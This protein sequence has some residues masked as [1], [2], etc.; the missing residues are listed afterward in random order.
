MSIFM[1]NLHTITYGVEDRGIAHSKNNYSKCVQYIGCPMKYMHKKLLNTG[2]NEFFIRRDGIKHVGVSDIWIKLDDPRV[3]EGGVKLLIGGQVIE[4]L[5]TI[6]FKESAEGKFKLTTDHILPMTGV[7]AIT[8]G[9]TCK[10]ASELVYTY[11][12]VALESYTY[13]DCMDILFTSEQYTRDCSSL[14]FTHPVTRLDVYTTEPVS[15]LQ[16]ATEHTDVFPLT[17][18][19]TNRNHNHYVLDFKQYTVNFTKLEKARLIRS[20]TAPLHIVGTYRNILRYLDGMYGLVY[21]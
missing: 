13:N 8:I 3:I 17:L 2:Y 4:T 9:I 16:F 18:H 5:H 10:W 20:S 6:C 7:H 15:S 14:N 19:D 12:T 11:S 21:L 1:E